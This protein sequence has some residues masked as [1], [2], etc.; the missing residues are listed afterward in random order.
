MKNDIN[1][2]NEINYLIISVSFYI[3]SLFVKLLPEIL[4]LFNDHIVITPL[5]Y[6]YG[7]IF[8]YLILSMFVPLV[9]F[10]N[11]N[12]YK[13]I[14]ILFLSISMADILG[15]F[16]TS[17]K[18]ARINKLLMFLLSLDRLEFYMTTLV[19]SIFI[20]LIYNIREISKIKILFVSIMTGLLTSGIKI[21][22]AFIQNEH[23]KFSS[24]EHLLLGITIISYVYFFIG[25]GYSHISKTNY[26][27][28]N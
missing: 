14:I 12:L 26:V 22:F 11:I 16:F 6:E 3:Y 23:Y 9:I 5:H 7:C 20:V 4:L 2:P 19:F 15:I 1:Y 28:Q 13:K 10:K 18:Y 17:Y 25:Y 21:M 8:S 24:I 27:N